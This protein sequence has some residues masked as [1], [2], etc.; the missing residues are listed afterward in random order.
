MINVLMPAKPGFPLL[1]IIP[2]LNA[3]ASSVAITSSSNPSALGHP[4]TLTAA[5]TPSTAI[6]TVTFYSGT[7]VLETEP[8]VNGN[9]T[10][11]TTQL[12]FGKA[13]LKA[14]Y[15]GDSANNPAHP[16]QFRTP[17]ALYLPP[18]FKPR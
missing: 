10:F 5:V 18:G 2:I 7:A 16:H 12:P 6:G 8:L 9:A 3:A 15:S 13:A 17:P 14:Y 4:V 1:L 11:T